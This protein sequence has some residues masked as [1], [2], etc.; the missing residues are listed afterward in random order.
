MYQ[1]S[2]QAEEVG[3]QGSPRPEPTA[4]SRSPPGRTGPAPRSGG[5]Q[6]PADGHGRR[7]GPRVL[8]GQ[9]LLGVISI[10]CTFYLEGRL[11][12]LSFGPAWRDK[13]T[14]LNSL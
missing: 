14:V 2:R 6:R 1:E 3:F 9:G 12:D 7:L 13:Q 10:S 8:E 4:V 5:A 11:E